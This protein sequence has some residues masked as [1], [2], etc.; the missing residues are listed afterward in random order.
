MLHSVIAIIVYYFEVFK[1]RNSALQSNNT[2]Q[3][4]HCFKYYILKESQARV[5]S[6]LHITKIIVL[7][8]VLEPYTLYKNIF[9]IEKYPNK[10]FLNKNKRYT[11]KIN[12]N[13][14]SQINLVI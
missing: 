9:R 13:F 4:F 2:E 5:H 3:H 10:T 7:K 1:L 11:G 14:P 8:C 12:F 6:N